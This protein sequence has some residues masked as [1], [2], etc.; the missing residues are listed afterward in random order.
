M[1]SSNNQGMVNMEGYFIFI[2]FSILS[3]IMIW[4]VWD[5]MNYEEE[6]TPYQIY[7]YNAN[8]QNQQ[9]HISDY[10]RVLELQEEV[11]KLEN[12]IKEQGDWNLYRLINKVGGEN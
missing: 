8:L 9:R 11:F 6:R 12:F 10:E 4:I 2:L 3:G 1:V 5:N 7:M